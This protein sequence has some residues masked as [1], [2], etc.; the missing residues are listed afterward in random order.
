MVYEAAANGA[1]LVFG[2]NLSEVPSSLLTTKG[3]AGT[4]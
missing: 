2:L 1:M 3:A 4:K